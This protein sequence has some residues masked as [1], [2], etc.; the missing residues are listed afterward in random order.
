MTQTFYE[1]M[2]QFLKGINAKDV[3]EIGSDVQLKL[4]FNLASHCET[5][6][7][8]NFPE[9]H[10]DMQGWYKLHQKM[11][12]VSNIK[13]LSGNAVDLS[14]LINHA[15]VI[16]LQN[17]LIDGNGT[18]TDLMWKYRREELE[19]SDEQWAELVDKFGQAEEDAYRGFLQV[20]KPGY[21]VRFGRPEED[22]KFRSMLIDKLG[23]ES[24]R[25]QTRELLYD[26]TCDVW[27]AYFIDNS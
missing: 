5:F 27:E 17:V 13:L 26:E 14:G 3:V 10:A 11:D 19:C 16:I 21:I 22:G 7:S 4:A 18:D 12:N 20:A 1:Y 9:D 24:T 8:V 2:A 23:V 6:Y 15:D 25:I